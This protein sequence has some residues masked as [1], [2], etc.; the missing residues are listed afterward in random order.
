[1]GTGRTA[2][3]GLG[4]AGRFASA[5]VLGLALGLLLAPGAGAA[6]FSLWPIYDERDDPVDR[7]HIRQGLGPILAAERSPDTAAREMAVRPLFRWR[8][9][10]IAD[11][12]EWEVLYPLMAYSRTERDREFQFLQLL[13]FREEG[14]LPEDRARRFDFFPF[15]LSGVT[16]A[17]EEYRALWPLGGRAVDRLGI[18][19]IEFV[20]F[21]LY[22]RF[23]RKETETRYFPWPLISRTRGE[24]HSGFRIVPL[25]G[26]EVKAGVFERRFA[27]WPLILFQR[28]GLDGDRPEE[29]RAFLPFFI[30]QRSPVRDSTTILWP[31]FT[32]TRDRE[33]QYEQWDLPWPLVRIARGEGRT[34]RRFLPLF[35]TEQRLMRNEFLLRELKSTD[36][37]LLF[38]VYSRSQ[39]EIPGSLKVR[40]RVLWWL[41]S[42]T[43]ET[44]M[45]GS[46]RRV[47]AWPLFRY[48]RDREGAIVF[49]TLALLE[50]FMPG[51]ERIERNYSPLW[52]VFTFRKNPEGDAVTSL[53]WNLIRHEETRQGTAVEVL[54]PLFAYRERGEDVSVS[55]L[56]GLLEYA[57]RQQTRSVRLFQGVTFTWTATAPPVAA[58][59]PMGDIR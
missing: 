34:I 42:D 16:E 20:L 46:T 51:N 11:R 28:T 44:G 7:V 5:A 13:N 6:G 49:Q 43:R 35:S 56:G 12:L 55:V 15:Y 26:E 30:R 17:G 37:H 48:Q 52:A 45:D 2:A 29:T 21:P 54:G 14:S 31:L 47:D 9:D 3:R 53:L 25:Y 57:V 40:D 38:P 24:G 22:A 4:R 41:Y 33:R 1:V 19:E 27:L 36:L 39:E 23:V 18:D 10:P 50:A 8:E 59:Q 58:L 32:F